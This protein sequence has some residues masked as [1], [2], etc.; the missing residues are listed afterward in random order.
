MYLLRGVLNVYP[1]PTL[2]RSNT[3]NASNTPDASNTPN[4]CNAPDTSDSISGSKED[5][6]TPGL[7]VFYSSCAITAGPYARYTRSE[8]C[9]R[10]NVVGEA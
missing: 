2:G 8:S 9:S 5:L 3:P 10:R 7:P 1:L 6:T 4:T